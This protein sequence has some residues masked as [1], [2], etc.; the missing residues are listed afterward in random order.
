MKI[1][2]G[3]VFIATLFLDWGNAFNWVVIPLNVAFLAS[4]VALSVR[5]SVVLKR[6][7]RKR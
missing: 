1:L 7:G 6:L 5:G 2:L 4:L 3:V